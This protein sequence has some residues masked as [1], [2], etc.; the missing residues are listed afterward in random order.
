MAE[1]LEAIAKQMIDR[2]EAMWYEESV[3]VIKEVKKDM[4][5]GLTLEN[6]QDYKEKDVVEVYELVEIKR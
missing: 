1:R 4:D 5:C 6:W 3:A 2:A